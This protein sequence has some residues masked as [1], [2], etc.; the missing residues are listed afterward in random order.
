MFFVRNVA[1]V[2]RHMPVVA[3]VVQDGVEQR[4]RRRLPFVS[5]IA[6][7]VAG[8]A[9]ASAE[10]EPGERPILEGVIGEHG[11][12]VLRHEQET[13]AEVR[14]VALRDFRIRVAV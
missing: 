13:L 1:A 2:E 9:H 7:A 6:E 3:V 10:P 14:A 11:E 4:D 8:V 5:R 12:F